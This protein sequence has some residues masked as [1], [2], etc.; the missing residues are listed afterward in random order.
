MSLALITFFNHLLGDWV[1]S[2][3]TGTLLSICHQF[4]PGRLHT[5]D[6][7]FD[8]FIL[9]L[10]ELLAGHFASIIVGIGLLKVYNVVIDIS[11]LPNSC[12][13]WQLFTHKEGGAKN[14]YPI[15]NAFRCIDVRN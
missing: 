9:S 13:S 12:W 2:K 5:L 1:S 11:K 15:S 3:A 4:L 10:D 6:T 14:L 8:R 7:I